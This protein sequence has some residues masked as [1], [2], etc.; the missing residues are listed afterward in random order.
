MRSRILLLLTLTCVVFAAVATAAIASGERRSDIPACEE[1]LT[2]GQALR[3]MDQPFGSILSREV[4]G[5]T[6]ICAYFGGSKA[7][8]IARGIGVFWGPWYD[9][10]KQVL[11][12]EGKKDFCA[13]SRKACDYLKQATGLSASDER[14]F[15]ALGKAMSQV[16]RVSLSYP[17]AF[18]KNPVIRWLPSAAVSPLDKTAWVAVFDL[19]NL[20]ALVVSCTDVKAEEPDMVCAL[21]A[22]RTV[23]NNT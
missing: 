8:G 17:V 23:Y 10:R 11:T 22:A 7:A 1:L 2:V 3:A 12:V 16:G 9:L 5:K 21:N 18:G 15:L 13:E 6:R 4:R 14:S 19:V 20:D